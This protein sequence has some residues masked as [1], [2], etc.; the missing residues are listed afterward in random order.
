MKSHHQWQ[1]TRLLRR[2]KIL[3]HVVWK[4]LRK[5]LASVRA[6]R[7]LRQLPGLLMDF[8]RKLQ[9]ILDVIIAD[10]DHSAQGIALSISLRYLRKSLVDWREQRL[11][12]NHGG[13]MLPLNQI[14]KRRSRSLIIALERLT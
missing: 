14:P 5:L 7:S 6:R 3:N 2:R 8:L 11:P 1:L 9:V 13:S 10:R 12:T 4:N